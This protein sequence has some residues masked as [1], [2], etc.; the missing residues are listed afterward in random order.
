MGFCPLDN[1]TDLIQRMRRGET[2][3]LGRL[4]NVVES[5]GGQVP[6]VMKE[7][8]AY[9]GHALRI[10]ITGPPGIGKSTLADRLTHQLRKHDLSVGVIAVDPTSPFSGGAILGD[11]VRMQ[12]HYLDRGVFIRSMATRGNLGGLPR[13]VGEVTNVIDASG[14]DYILIETVGVGQTELNVVKNVDTVLVVLAPGYGDN[15]QM[16]KAGL[17][18]IADILSLIH[19]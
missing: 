13:A 7:I 1:I 14:K 11:R 4:V 17:M 12:R 2:L 6:L 8:H 9:T 18:E 19:I 10:G 16:M 5:G 15:I 3:A